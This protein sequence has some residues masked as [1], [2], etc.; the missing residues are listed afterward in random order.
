MAYKSELFVK[1]LSEKLKEL[2]GWD[3][4]I[5]HEN[6]VEVQLCK[7]IDQFGHADLLLCVWLSFWNG[8]DKDGVMIVRME[9][10]GETIA[11][12]TLRGR[13]NYDSDSIQSAC[14]QIAE[15][16]RRSV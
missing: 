14:D 9:K 1:T 11:F 8:S 13:F 4:V 10:S 3:D 2:L 15:I 16:V 6:P 5:S 12:Q 7:G